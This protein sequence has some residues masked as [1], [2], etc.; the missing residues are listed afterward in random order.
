MGGVFVIYLYKNVD[1]I[2]IFDFYDMPEERILKMVNYKKKE[3]KIMCYATF[4]LLKYALNL[5][6]GIEISKKTC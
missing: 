6:Y 1:N 3:D 2:P 4:Q 5:E